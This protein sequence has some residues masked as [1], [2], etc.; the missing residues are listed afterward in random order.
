M[1]NPSHKK[2]PIPPLAGP[3]PGAIP[4]MSLQFQPMLPAHRHNL[5]VPGHLNNFCHLDIQMLRCL[6]LLKS[7]FLNLCNRLLFSLG[8]KADASTYWREF[9]SPGE[10]LH[11]SDFGSISVVKT[12]SPGADGLLVSAHDAKSSPIAV[13]PAANLPTIV[14]LESSSLSGNVS[15]PMIG[16]VEMKNSSEPAL[17]AVANSEKIG[18]AVT[19]GNSVAPPVHV[20]RFI[21]YKF[22]SGLCCFLFG[23]QF[24]C[25]FETTTTQVTVVYGDGFSSK[26]RENV[27]KDVVITEI[28]GTTPSDEKIVELGPLVYE[29]KA[30]EKSTFKTLLES[31]NIGSDCMWNQAMRAVINDRRYGALKSLCEQKQA[32]NE[33]HAKA[34]EEQKRNRVEYL[35]FLK[36]FNFIKA[37]SQW[38]KV[39]DRLET[40]ERCS[41]LEK[42]NRLEIFQRMV[43]VEVVTPVT[44][45]VMVSEECVKV[46]DVLVVV[47]DVWKLMMCRWLLVVVVV[48]ID[49]LVGSRDQLVAVD[50]GDVGGRGVH[51]SIWEIT[52]SSKWEDWKSLFGDRQVASFAFIDLEFVTR[53]QGLLE[54]DN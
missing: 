11:A 12:S 48:L 47:S 43:V 50:G 17:P 5:M 37:S 14:A 45:V 44:V 3:A 30:E 52:A 33:E 38:W 13:S 7:N 26:N 1:L 10:N 41:R 4:S 49:E 9:T 35:E 19:L 25:S 15:S 6:N 34:L 21:C 31:A 36:S 24:F 39:Q 32:F 27:K 16:T 42:I 18:I 46:D 53:L 8:Q 54:N 40:D 23:I 28:G 22:A 29:S 51:G 20:F 2:P